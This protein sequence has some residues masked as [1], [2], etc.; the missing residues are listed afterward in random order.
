MMSFVTSTG[1]ASKKKRK[2]DSETVSDSTDPK[3]KVK[4]TYSQKEIVHCLMKQ[5]K[6]EKKNDV[7]YENWQ[8]NNPIC[9]NKVIKCIQGKGVGNAYNHLNS[10]N[11]YG[12]TD[13]D[14]QVIVSEMKTT[15]KKAEELLEGIY[16]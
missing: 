2:S 16:I 15:G 6:V 11:C 14:L 5:L 7:T 8:C 12:G 3:A 10:K 4:K 9:K 1:N 13:V